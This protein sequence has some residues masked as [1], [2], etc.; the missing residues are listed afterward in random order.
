MPETLFFINPAQSQHALELPVLT[1]NNEV[2]AVVELGL[3]ARSDRPQIKQAFLG[4]VALPK[5]FDLE[6]IFMFAYF[7]HEGPPG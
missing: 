7:E 2:R 1:G 5:L 4:P 6:E 3:K